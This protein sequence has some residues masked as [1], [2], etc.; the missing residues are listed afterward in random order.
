MCARVRLGRCR[1]VGGDLGVSLKVVECASMRRW[2]GFEWNRGIQGVL[3][4]LEGFTD[5]A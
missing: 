5:E 4:V 3:N 2:V 1:G